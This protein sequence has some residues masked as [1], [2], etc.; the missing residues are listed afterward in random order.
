MLPPGGVIMAVAT[1]RI[2]D[3]LGLSET[4]LMQKALRSFL[5]EQ[6]RAVLAARLEILARYRAADLAELEQK[7]ADGTVVEH[8]GWEDLITAENL[9]AR[10]E[11]LDVYLR[12]L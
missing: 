2:A 11:D 4:E 3:F 10:L 5:L 6:R 12:D 1:P 9:G 7:I 8:P